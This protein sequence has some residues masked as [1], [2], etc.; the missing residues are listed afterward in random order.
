MT[1]RRVLDETGCWQLAV[2]GGDV[3]AS[4]HQRG[5]ASVYYTT[6]AFDLSSDERGR[7]NLSPSTVARRYHDT[8]S[9]DTALATLEN[10]IRTALEPSDTHPRDV[11]PA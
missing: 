6:A 8:A 11:S 9:P 4:F 7:T 10:R 3:T 5:M 1:H 2:C